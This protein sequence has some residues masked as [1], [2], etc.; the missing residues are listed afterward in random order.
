MTAKLIILTLALCLS[1]NAVLLSG[2]I[3]PIRCPVYIREQAICFS[4]GN[5]YTDQCRADQFQPG[6]K[7]LFD[8]GFPVNREACAAK[9]K[10]T[11][12]VCP[13]YIAAQGFCY[14]NGQVYTD[15]CYAHKVNASLYSLFQCPTPFKG[16]LCN[17]ICT[18]YVRN[19]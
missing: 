7:P 6:L 10:A 16:T 19:Q 4:D 13:K 14:N 3:V 17:Y 1:A 15:D 11:V 5:L 18:Y 8:C 9:C 12:A 2:P